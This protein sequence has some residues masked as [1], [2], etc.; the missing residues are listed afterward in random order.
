MLLIGALVWAMPAGADPPG[1]S[2]DP[3]PVPDVSVPAPAPAS[4][5]PPDAAPSPDI[6]PDVPEEQPEALADARPTAFADLLAVAKRA[7]FSGDHPEALDL[8]QGLQIRML[9]GETPAFDV[10]AEAMVFLGEI[11]YT[12]GREPEATSAF[13]WLLV[14][15]SEYPIS[16][17]HHPIE[18]VGW[19]ETIRRVVIEEQGEEQ[20]IEEEPL[21]VVH[22]PPPTSYLPL[23]VPQ[24]IEGRTGPGLVFGTLQVGFGIASIAT[25]ANLDALNVDP[26]IHPQGWTAQ[27]IDSRVRARRFG[28]QWP[29]TVAFYGTWLWSHADA[30]KAWRRKHQTPVV[31]LS[32]R[33]GGVSVT[34][35]SPF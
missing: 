19:F 4:D 24:F 32:P 12:Q 25:F 17:Y 11:L 6:P 31:G 16:P 33:P 26:T 13:R 21:P 27:Q 7:Y 1:D 30:R 9:Q 23:G 15:D 28:I 3:A 35:G 8:L 20:T 29:L 10:A 34:L 2:E 5:G 14:R 22:P 18:V